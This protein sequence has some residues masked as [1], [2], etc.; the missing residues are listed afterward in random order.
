MSDLIVGIDLGTTNSLI[1]FSDGHGSRIIASPQGL[2][3]LPSVVHVDPVT[4]ALEVGAS[5]LGRAVE[6]PMETIYSV[7]RL[8]GKSLDEVRGELPFVP[9]RIVAH[10]PQDGPSAEGV[11]GIAAVQVGRFRLTPQEIS[12]A[13]L[14]ELKRWAEA[15]FH[16]PITKAVL[17][18]PAYFDDAQRQ[19]TRHAAS[20]AG[21][22]VIRI[23]NEPTAAALA[24]G[25]D[26]AAGSAD[27]TIAVYD[28][29]GGTFDVSILRVEKGVFRVLATCG[30]THLGGD[31]MDRQLMLLLQGDI[32]KQFGS[33]IEFDPST[34]QA[35]RN[36]SE[37]VKLTLSQATS[38]A[39]EIDLGQGRLYQASF[40]REGYE[41][42]IAEI[43]GKTLD[44]CATALMEAQLGPGGVER[45]VM[46]GGATFIP[47]VR[48]AV[49]RFFNAEVYTAIDPM[50]TVALGAAVQGSILGGKK[51][52]ALLLDIV[53]LS[54]GIETAGG[55]VTKLIGKGS[56]IPCHAETLF[57][58]FVDG[59]SN[60]KIHILQG[61]RELVKDCRS[62]GQFI[63]GGLPPMPA[64]I[65]RIAISLLVDAS[66]ILSVSAKEERSGA[67][68]SI[69]VIPSHGLNPKEVTRMIKEGLEHRPDDLLEHWLIDL[70]NQIRLDTSAIEKALASVGDQVEVAYRQELVGL[71]QALR[72]MLEW[73][74]TEKIARA[75]HFMNQ[76]STHLAEL[77]IAKALREA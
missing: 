13:I 43:I 64:G 37:S 54:L 28:F 44:C 26:R 58:T 67:S 39:V 73:N 48:R 74:D 52:N 77:A 71:I 41:N 1:A 57:T 12:A 32:R 59:Q 76:K 63:L 15:H 62:L 60:V 8:M 3:S 14:A 35:L 45:V 51:R 18:V 68:A 5:A 40:T 70:H 47:A 22:E 19:A 36:F 31:D 49:G 55:A 9:Y 72:E 16:Q 11:A 4:G 2:K 69:Q 42:L 53:P 24:Y 20:I 50:Q 29:G 30:N 65:P 46:V 27:A 7:K 61:E 33:A 21:L 56:N 17:T 23:V 75:L 66:G 38:A 34:Q 10:T 25:L 6:R